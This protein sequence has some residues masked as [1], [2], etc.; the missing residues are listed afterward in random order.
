MHCAGAGRREWHDT[1]CILCGLFYDSRKQCTCVRTYVRTHAQ[2]D[3]A[4]WLYVGGTATHALRLDPYTFWVESGRRANH[5]RAL[6]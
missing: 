5:L 4:S 1:Q 6:S 2:S 3:G